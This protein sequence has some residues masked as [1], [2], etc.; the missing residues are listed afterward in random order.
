MFLTVNKKIIFF[1]KIVKFLF[2][3]SMKAKT[4]LKENIEIDFYS[5]QSTFLSE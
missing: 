2:A 3:K 4:N 5:K 1:F